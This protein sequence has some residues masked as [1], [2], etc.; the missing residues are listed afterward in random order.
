MTAWADDIF[1]SYKISKSH[2]TRS[3]G[4]CVLQA[5]RCISIVKLKFIGN[6]LLRSVHNSRHA[7]SICHA[8]IGSQE[9]R[10]IYIIRDPWN[11]YRPHCNFST[12]F[13]TSLI[14]SRFRYRAFYGLCCLLR[15]TRSRE[16]KANDLNLVGHQTITAGLNWI[17]I[18]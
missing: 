18:S 7:E 11:L 12:C 16:E 1:Q 17:D 10:E 2:G 8:N 5:D 9:R 13:C 14:N 4:S 6:I 15:D 3:F